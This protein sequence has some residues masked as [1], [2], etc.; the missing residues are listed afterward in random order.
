MPVAIEPFHPDDLLAIMRLASRTLPEEYPYEFYLQMARVQ[1]RH[2]RVAKDAA[3]STV[4]GFIVVAKEPGMK[5]NL[6]LFAVDPA[7]QGQGIGRALLR[8]VQRGLT[9]DQ[10]RALE[11]QVRSD[12]RRAIEFYRREGFTVVGRETAVYKDGADALAM[13]KPLL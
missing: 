11:L 7:Q 12:N 10:V 13:S 5:A 2:F 3:T 9:L 1:G 6:L 4:L 8:D